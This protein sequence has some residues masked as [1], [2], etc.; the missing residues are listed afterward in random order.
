ML[1]KSAFLCTEKEESNLRNGNQLTDKEKQLE[2]TFLQKYFYL[3]TLT[4]EADLEV[5]IKHPWIHGSASSAIST[6]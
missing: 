5:S 2:A 1:N 4:R 3:T 6:D